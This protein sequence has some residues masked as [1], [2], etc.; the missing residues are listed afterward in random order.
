[1]SEKFK[2]YLYISGVCLVLLIFL[3]IITSER[4]YAKGGEKITPWC[5]TC[6]TLPPACV[7]S[8]A[9]INQEWQHQG[10][11]GKSHRKTLE[12]QNCCI[13]NTK[14]DPKCKPSVH[15]CGEWFYY[16][17][18]NCTGDHVFAFDIPGGKGCNK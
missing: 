11:S 6:I 5:D 2:S 12:E 10:Q 18:E 14:P 16:T 13:G 3:I 7:Y 4:A 15:R 1:M 9:C 17:D 8:T